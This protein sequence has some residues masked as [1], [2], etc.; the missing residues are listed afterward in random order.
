MKTAPF[1]R[2]PVRSAREVLIDECRLCFAAAAGC[3]VVGLL[4]T[5]YHRWCGQP[6]SLAALLVVG[7]FYGIMGV[8]RLV[9][10]LMT[11]AGAQVRNEIGH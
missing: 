11:P 2:T 9:K 1:D 3:S 6:S 4:A 10:Y 8:G 7:G 5:S